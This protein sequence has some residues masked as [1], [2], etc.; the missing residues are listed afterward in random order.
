MES[1]SIMPTIVLTV[2]IHSPPPLLPPKYKQL[3]IVIQLQNSFYSLASVG[4][5]PRV[6]EV[7]Y[8]LAK[9]KVVC[10]LMLEM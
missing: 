10:N 3:H 4:V 1:I 7:N 6:N 9:I 5:S 8:F 2:L